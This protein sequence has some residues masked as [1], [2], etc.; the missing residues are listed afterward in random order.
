MAQAM[1]QV[2]REW[3][4]DQRAPDR[5]LQVTWHPDRR[6]AVL[7]VWH[8][9]SCVST[10]QLS[11]DDAGRMITHLADALVAA[12]TST[13][14]PPAAPRERRAKRLRRRWR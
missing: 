2:N 13:T 5:Q 8:G 11:I 6:T 14:H 9:A 10:F 12:A 1:S 4:A 7:S 3:F